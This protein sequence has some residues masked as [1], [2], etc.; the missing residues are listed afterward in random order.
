MLM[1]RPML[2]FVVVLCALFMGA[3][4]ASAQDHAANDG[5]LHFAQFASCPLESGNAIENCKIGYR[6]F[7][8]PNSSRSNAVL[9][10]T[11]Y[12][13]TSNDLKMF[14]GPDRMVDTTQYFVVAIDALGDGVSSS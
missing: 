11:W 9:F 14:F 3:R 7:G 8:V 13:G 10:F 4:A 2:M 1:K 5:D 6:T 12:N